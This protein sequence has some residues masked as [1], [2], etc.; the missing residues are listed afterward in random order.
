M[1]VA[2][3]NQDNI[4]SENR[5]YIIHGYT[6][7]VHD[8]WFP[9]LK[10]QLSAKGIAVEVIEMP[11]PNQPIAADWLEQVYARIGTPDRHTYIVGHSLGCIT[12][13][14]YMQEQL[15]IA[16]VQL[17]GVLLVSGF[18]ESLYTLPQL[19]EFVQIPVQYE[20]LIAAIPQRVV[21]AAADDDIVPVVFS[22]HFA[23]HA[24]AELHELEH[25]GHFLDHDGFTEFP[26]VLELLERMISTR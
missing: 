3:S 13:L 17:G 18:D 5:V 15:A 26:L 22:R 19:D 11:D 7:S 8:N 24:Q 21:V 4:L 1:T 20:P 2:S 16:P 9:W 25:G 10:E 14:L 6:A 23:E 12:T